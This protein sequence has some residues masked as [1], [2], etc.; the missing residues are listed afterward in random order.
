MDGPG[1][2]PTQSHTYPDSPDDH[3]VTVPAS[4][5]TQALGRHLSDVH[6]YNIAPSVQF[7][8]GSRRPADEAYRHLQRPGDDA[9]GT[10]WPIRSCE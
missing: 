7:T 4:K 8:L 1:T 6:V 2:L 9:I 5:T 10:T 3:I